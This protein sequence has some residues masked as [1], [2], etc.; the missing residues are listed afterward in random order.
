MPIKAFATAKTRLSD[1]LS[2][3]E[4]GRLAEAMARDVLWALHTAPGITGIAILS[5][6]P[7]LTP[8]AAAVGARVYPEQPG[9]NYR[10]GLARVAAALEREGV[11]HLLVVPADLPTL[12]AA[13]VEQLL[14]A[15]EG[16]ITL[17]PAPDGGTN[18]LVLSPPTALPFLYGPES[19]SQHLAAATALGGTVRTTSL[20]GFARDVD[21][22]DDVRWLLEQR[23]ACATLAW[24]QAS[25]IKARLQ[26]KDPETLNL[27]P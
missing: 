17:C 24:L 4:C 21:N 15:H 8:L 3:T 20:S 2:R 14:G 13:A 10:A 6:E 18:A 1:G 9:E 19:A 5:D 23:L 25:G 22:L 26:L 16:G 11:K 7:G 12:S 27:K